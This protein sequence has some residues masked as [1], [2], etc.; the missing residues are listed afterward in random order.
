MK[1][2]IL[3]ML[4]DKFPGF[5]RSAYI[6]DIL[7]LLAMEL[8][9][10]LN[11]PNVSLINFRN[12]VLD[13]DNLTLRPHSPDLNFMH[14]VNVDYDPKALPDERLQSIL[15]SFVSNNRQDLH[16]LRAGVRREVN[17]LVEKCR[18]VF[19]F[20]ALRVLGS[21]PSYLY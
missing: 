5:Q 18:L 6:T 12:G 21:L 3:A 7:Q 14:V 4:K 9:R 13:V 11:K 1:V 16:L 10:S 2:L 19:G 15:L 20:T 17:Y 8:R